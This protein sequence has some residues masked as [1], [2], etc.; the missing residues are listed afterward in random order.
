M[1]R[2]GLSKIQLQQVRLGH[3]KSGKCAYSHQIATS[4][5]IPVKLR[6]PAKVGKNPVKL[7]HP[8]AQHNTEW[9]SGKNGA[10]TEVDLGANSKLS[11]WWPMHVGYFNMPPKKN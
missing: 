8:E 11:F 3:S 6:H 5:R 2:A 10:G 7:R 4:L 1:K 9:V